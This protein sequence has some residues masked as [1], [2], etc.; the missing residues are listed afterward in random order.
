[1]CDDSKPGMM[2]AAVCVNTCELMNSSQKKSN[3]YVTYTVERVIDGDTLKLT[4]GEEVQLIGI[5][6][7]EDEKMGQE[8]TEFVKQLIRP[9]FDLFLEF[10][11]QKRD[12]YGRL[13]AYVHKCPVSV[14]F[15][16]PDFK[17]SLYVSKYDGLDCHL[18]NALILHS[19]YATPMTI[20]PNVKYA[21]L[22][23]RIYEEVR[24]QKRGLWSEEKE[25]LDIAGSYFDY[26]GGYVGASRNWKLEIRK[27]GSVWIVN[28][29]QETL[30]L[31]P[32][33]ITDSIIIDAETKLIISKEK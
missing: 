27:E 2:C 14:P 7:P 22:F 33:D 1:M 13:L 3:D 21:D 8:A 19:G 11:V 32:G 30:Q 28:I 12:K 18:I 25:I 10:D 4:N 15:V 17:I 5:K 26:I 9:G 23:K 16:P 31:L 6:T 29:S 24:E 20:P